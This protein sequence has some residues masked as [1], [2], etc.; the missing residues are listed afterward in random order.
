MEK[1]IILCLLY[2]LSRTNTLSNCVI[3]G[4]LH[5]CTPQERLRFFYPLRSLATSIYVSS[6]TPIS[7]EDI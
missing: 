1:E 7:I 3:R 5:V 6:A 2:Q 4:L